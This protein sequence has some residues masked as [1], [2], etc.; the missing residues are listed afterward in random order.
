MNDRTSISVSELAKDDTSPASIIDVRTPVEHRE[1]HISG[2]RH[3]PLDSFDPE[4]DV[5]NGE[6]PTY[7]LCRSGKRAEQA[8]ERCRKAGCSNV[9]VVE[10]GIQAWI[11]AGY[12][13][14]RGESGMSLERQVRIA[15]GTLVLLGVLLALFIHPAGIYLSAFVGAGL[16]VAGITDFCGMG[17]LLAKMPWNQ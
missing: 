9:Q 12:P 15:A 3:V 10:G 4:V 13:V 8:R 7:L 17:L 16:I 11:D 6:R 1:V 2:A 14:T 5:T